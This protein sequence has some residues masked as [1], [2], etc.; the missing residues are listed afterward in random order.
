MLDNSRD[1]SH[2]NSCSFSCLPV[3]FDGTEQWGNLYLTTGKLG[4]KSKL[5][6]VL[7]LKHLIFKTCLQRTSAASNP[8]LITPER[9]TVKDWCTWFL[10]HFFFIPHFILSDLWARGVLLLLRQQRLL[11]L[12]NTRRSQ[13]LKV[14]QGFY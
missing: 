11:L 4:I 1:F 14:R 6:R 8:C 10:A 13:R 3:I 2:M 7:F 12:T 5:L 9:R